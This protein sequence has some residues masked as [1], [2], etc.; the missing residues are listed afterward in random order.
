VAQLQLQL[1]QLART[2][3][4]LRK[5]LDERDQRVP[6]QPASLDDVQGVQTDLENFKYDVNRKRDTATAVSARALSVRGTIAALARASNVRTGPRAGTSTVNDR[7]GGAEI[8]GANVTFSGNLYKDY[9]L[10]RD[11]GYTLRL[12]AAPAQQGNNDRFFGVQDAYLNYQL[13]PT[14]SPETS[15]LELVFG[16]QLLPFGLEVS[17]TEE[18]RPVISSAQ[19]ASRL[20]L[21]TRQIGLLVKGDLY[22]T[23]DYGYDYRQTL[24]SY[25][26]GVVNGNGPNTADDNNRGDFIGRIALTLPSG[27]NSWLRQITFGASGYWGQQNLTAQ[28]FDVTTN[29]VRTRLL[30]KHGERT[31]L[32]LDFTYNHEPFGITYELIAGRD[33]RMT[34]GTRAQPLSSLEQVE[35]R[36]HTLTLFY[37]IGAQFVRG[38]RN[39]GRYDD[40]WPKSYQVFLRLDRFDPDRRAADDEADIGTLGLNV[41]FAQT[42]KFQLNYSRRLV[43]ELERGSQSRRYSNEVVGQFQFGF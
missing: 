10:G 4:E 39:Q 37:N 6:A 28:P 31:R 12:A 19:F 20:G 43:H 25:A 9:E 22:P 8:G 30:S 40:W 21:G 11:L 3:D 24:V 34:R 16:Q 38:Y 41:F 42:T 18:L 17:A 13:L 15:R 26:F 1:R 29:A 5:E 2:V 32:G 35:S 14:V 27:Y 23:M 36:S 33:E 7:Q